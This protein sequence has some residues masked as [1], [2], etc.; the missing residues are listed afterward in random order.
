MVTF[1]ISI[2]I[3]IGA[4][5]AMGRSKDLPNVCM[6]VIPFTVSHSAFENC[7]INHV[8]SILDFRS[9]F[10]G[11]RSPRLEQKISSFILLPCPTEHPLYWKNLGILISGCTFS[12]RI[13]I[14][15][16]LRVLAF[17]RKQDASD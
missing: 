2:S 10:S 4:N 6:P 14:L 17:L 16:F 8:I 11:P 7:G 12:L 13:P 15:S 3:L 5:T 1:N 9:V